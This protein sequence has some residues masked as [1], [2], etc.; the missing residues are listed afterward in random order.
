MRNEP[1]PAWLPVLALADTVGAGAKETTTTA[2]SPT[3]AS[4][5][6]LAQTKMGGIVGSAVLAG[7]PPTLRAVLLAGSLV[8]I[9]KATVFGHG[10]FVLL[11][12]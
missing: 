7:V 3:P 8:H 5:T 10:E 11:P 6:R 9:G 2:S 4:A 1:T 12:R